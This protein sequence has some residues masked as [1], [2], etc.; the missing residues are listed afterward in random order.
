MLSYFQPTL[1]GNNL[2]SATMA[3]IYAIFT[4]FNCYFGKTSR[5]SEEEPDAKGYETTSTI[6]STLSNV[7]KPKV[8][9][10]S[11]R[12][13][14]RTNNNNAKSPIINSGMKKVALFRRYK[15]QRKQD[16]ECGPGVMLISMRH[17]GHVLSTQAESPT[18]PVP[19]PVTSRRHSR[20]GRY[21]TG[22]IRKRAVKA[23]VR[24]ATDSD[25]TDEGKL[26]QALGNICCLMFAFCHDQ[27]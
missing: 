27:I 10:S 16:F 2:I 21:S 15:A 12:Q 11:K 23:K 25:S 24:S 1:V 20:K 7:E 19:T 4:S 18:H 26:G 5:G 14:A 6:G 13:A 22:S 8:P 9:P 17:P 3:K